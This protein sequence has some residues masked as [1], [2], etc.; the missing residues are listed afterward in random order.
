ML[1]WFIVVQE[2]RRRLETK[3]NFYQCIMYLYLGT[4]SEEQQ[5]WGERLT[6]FQA[7]LDRLNEALKLNKAEDAAIEDSLRFTLDVVGGK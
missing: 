5:K 3:A 2:W 4:Q 1:L 7:A 6:Y